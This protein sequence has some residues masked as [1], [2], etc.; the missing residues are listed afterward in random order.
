MTQD[1]ATRMP[2]TTRLMRAGYA[3]ACARL[4]SDAAW[5]YDPVSWLVSVGNWGQWRELASAY[6]Y[7]ERVLEIGFGTG[8]LLTV[9]SEQNRVVAGLDASPQMA[10]RAKSRLVCSTG[11]VALAQ[12]RSQT[13]PWA[14]HCFDTVVATFPAEFI[15]APETLAECARV[16][17]SPGGRLVIGGLWVSLDNARLAKFLTVFYGAPS[18][19]ILRTLKDRLA[20]LGFTPVLIERQ[21]A[22]AR[23]GILVADLHGQ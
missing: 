17:R 19:S 15:T 8:R 6:I 22:W 11:N 14:E 20:R 21:H 10:V 18:E 9:L 23:V 13:M 1:G 16:L 3:W 12:G 5:A 4:Y 2:L 7:G